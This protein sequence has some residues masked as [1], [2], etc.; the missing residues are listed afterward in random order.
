[1][2][3]SDEHIEPL[4]LLAIARPAVGRRYRWAATSPARGT[5][6]L[7][8]PHGPGPWTT[9]RWK[10]YAVRWARCI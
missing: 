5:V 1:M 9:G 4:R 3:G 7:R 10:R 6:Q 2:A 8:H